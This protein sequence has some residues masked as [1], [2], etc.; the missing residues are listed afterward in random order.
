MTT[1]DCIVTFL[2]NLKNKFEIKVKN[3]VTRNTFILSFLIFL[4]SIQNFERILEEK[5]T[6]QKLY[7]IIIG[8]KFR[9]S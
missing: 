6:S 7:L 9:N 8:I 1:S 4:I 2:K 3:V 5:N